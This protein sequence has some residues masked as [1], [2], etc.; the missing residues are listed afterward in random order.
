MFEYLVTLLIFTVPLVIYGFSQKQFRQVIIKV[1][2]VLTPI[3]AVWDYIA[4]HIL[5][6][7]SFNPDTIVGL[8][9]FGLPLEEWLFIPLVS[10]SVAT[11][12][13]YIARRQEVKF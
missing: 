7:W 3:G 12:A 13:L 1:G 5:K 4:I 10:M 6:I 9:F 8:S 11:V 2:I